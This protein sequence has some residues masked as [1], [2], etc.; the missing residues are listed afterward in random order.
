MQNQALKIELQVA[1]DARQALS[2]TA[3]KNSKV[4]GTTSLDFQQW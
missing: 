1:D 4:S 2:A 3:R